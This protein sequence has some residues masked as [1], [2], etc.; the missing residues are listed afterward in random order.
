MSP[1]YCVGA[2]IRRFSITNASGM[3]QVDNFQSLRSVISSPPGIGLYQGM[4]QIIM[5]A[6]SRK[7]SHTAKFPTIESLNF[8]LKPYYPLLLNTFPIF[9]LPRSLHSFYPKVFFNCLQSESLPFVFLIALSLRAKSPLN[10]HGTQ[11]P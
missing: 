10:S 8:W 6:C 3:T 2:S 4:G 1:Q 7:L 9:C 11:G 5:N